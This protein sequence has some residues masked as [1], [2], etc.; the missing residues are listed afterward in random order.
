MAHP[1]F[2]FGA[3]EQV[4]TQYETQL[5]QHVKPRI[6]HQPN[7]S[8]NA[9]ANT[10]HGFAIFMA[11]VGALRPYGLRRRLTL[12]LGLFSNKHAILRQCSESPRHVIST[13]SAFTHF[14]GRIHF[15]VSH[16]LSVAYACSNS[17]PQ[18]AI[19]EQESREHTQVPILF[20]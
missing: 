2:F 5:P 9:D 18:R 7:R 14:S 6:C 12:A 17:K 11:S 3:T 15:S 13:H 10:G 16:R 1:H 8:F 4:H 19:W 20:F